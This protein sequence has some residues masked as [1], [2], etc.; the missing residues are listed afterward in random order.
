MATV[1]T[2]EDRRTESCGNVFLDLGFP[3]DEA[4]ILAM[5]SD[6]MCR[7]ALWLRDSGVTPPQAA[8]QLGV[9]QTRIAELMQ[10]KWDRFSL[11]ALIQLAIRAGQRVE[12]KVA[13]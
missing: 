6:L 4:I 8:E 7:L 3:P 13:A 10:G 12:L 2:D 1:E 5:R 9:S 11:D